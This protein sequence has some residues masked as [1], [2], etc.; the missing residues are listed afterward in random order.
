MTQDVPW[1]IRPANGQDVSFIYATWLNSY[2]SD[3]Q[4]GLSCRTTIFYSAYN[5]ILDHILDSDNSQT[6]VACLPDDPNVILGYLVFERDRI[7]YVFV[8]EV[9]RKTGIARSLIQAA[10]L[11]QTIFITHRTR[12]A[13]PIISSHA[14]L[15]YNPF[16]LFN[17][18]ENHGSANQEASY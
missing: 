5:R 15:I 11:P 8:K 4:I 6:L 7:H 17:Q 12:S 16:L 9:F 18:G 3:S 10:N 13:E 14:K 2:R 1:T